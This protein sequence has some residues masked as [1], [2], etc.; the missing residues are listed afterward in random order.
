[1]QR[2]SLQV[3]TQLSKF[4]HWTGYLRSY[5]QMPCLQSQSPCFASIWIRMWFGSPGVARVFYQRSE[6][7]QNHFSAKCS[8]VMNDTEPRRTRLASAA[9]RNP[10][11][12]PHSPRF[13]PSRNA[14]KNTPKAPTASK[15]LINC[16][17]AS[18]KSDD[19]QTGKSL[20]KGGKSSRRG[21]STNWHRPYVG[22]FG[23]PSASAA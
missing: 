23:R 1:M 2:A 3:G 9:A 6:L 5:L 10:V 20:Q 16:H 13:V 11:A 19:T 7:S 14:W 4:T 18:A 22:T 12:P 17:R 15:T 21:C 8:T